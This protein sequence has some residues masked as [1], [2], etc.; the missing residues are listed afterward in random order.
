MARRGPSRPVPGSI[1]SATTARPLP[2]TGHGSGSEETALPVVHLPPPVSRIQAEV[3]LREAHAPKLAK[4]DLVAGQY[5]VEGC[6]THGG[7]GWIYLAVDRNLDNRYVVLKGLIDSENEA[8]ARLAVAESRVLAASEHLNIVRIYNV[9]THPDPH[10]ADSRNRYIVM[11]FVGGVSLFEMMTDHAGELRAEHVANYGREILA[12][13]GYL[14]DQGLLYCDMSPQNVIQGEHRVKVIDLGAIREIGDKD[15]PIVGTP[16]YRVSAAEIAEHGLTVRSDIYSVGATLKALLEVSV[17]GINPPREIKSGVRSLRHVLA[18]ATAG[19]H[20]R[21]ASTA[22]MAAQLDGV[23]AELH[24]LRDGRPRPAVSSLFSDT[25]ALLDDGLGQ[26]PPLDRWLELE[27]PGF[28]DGRP[29][30]ASAVSALPVPTPEENAEVET[31]FRLGRVRLARADPEGAEECFLLARAGLGDRA[32][33]NWRMIWHMALL[34]LANED[35][36]SAGELFGEVYW[37]LPGEQAPK[38]ALGYCA[39]S[40][41]EI[42]TAEQYYHA[43]WT[44]DRS[45]VSAAFGLARI[46]LSRGS[47]DKAVDVLGEVPEASR[48]HDAAAIAAIRV[49]AAT[50]PNGGPPD[51]EDLQAARKRLEGLD[52]DSEEAL[53]RLATIV[54]ETELELAGPRR[55]KE[56][57]IALAGAYRKLARQARNR[58]EHGVLVDR[59]NEVRPRTKFEHE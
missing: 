53:D 9:V 24:S 25:V 49:L 6:I 5:R 26:P 36:G 21:Y 39:E 33:Q 51:P 1:T 44:R 48:H 45:Q 34:M 57:R 16:D 14:H 28:T 19:F 52:L 55:K 8:A 58:N 29:S 20:Q 22:G 13:L 11:D 23:L 7:F 47:R 4:G 17:D 30:P 18:R 59:A 54:R 40:G 41:T 46:H 15:S 43:V 3:D 37:N 10:K 31:Q 35:F 12:A 27:L 56:A 50:L 38:I 32:H 2:T 42:Q